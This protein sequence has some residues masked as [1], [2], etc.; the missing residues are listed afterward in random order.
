MVGCTLQASLAPVNHPADLPHPSPLPPT[1]LPVTPAPP[2]PLRGLPAPITDL[3]QLHGPSAAICHPDPIHPSYLLQGLSAPITD[4][5]RL[6][7][8]DQRLYL[9]ATRGQGGTRVLGGIKTGTKKLF[10]RRVRVRSGSGARIPLSHTSL[11]LHTFQAE[12]HEL[13]EIDA[14]CVLDFYVHESTQRQGIGKLLF[15]V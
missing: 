15:E 11:S 14:L 9:Y 2:C 5:W 6:Q 7:G 12:S 13:H 8:T 3:C 10:V 4:L 1:P